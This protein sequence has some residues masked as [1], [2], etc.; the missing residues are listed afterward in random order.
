MRTACPSYN[1]RP[2]RV[3]GR[4]LLVVAVLLAACGRQAVD[5][6]HDR[7]EAIRA[8][9]FLTCGIWPEVRGFAMAAPGGGYAGF[10]VDICRAVAA[11]I[12]GDP[13]QA[14]FV[15]TR[16]VPDFLASADTDLVA[17][18]LTWMLSRERPVGLRFG[19]VTFHDGQTFLVPRASGVT[20]MAELSGRSICMETGSP[21]E[22]SIA[23]LFRARGL[24]LEEVHLE[25]ESD[26]GAA[27]AS[28]RC[29]AYTGDQTMLGSIRAGLP[30]PADFVILSELVSK[31]PLAPVVRQ[32][33]TRLLDVLQWTVFALVAAE[34]LG[35]TSANVER[36]LA[37]DDYD[38][39]RLLGV[40]PGNGSALG[41]S[42]RW[43]F[44]A[45]AAV[46]NY[47]EIFERHLGTASNIGLERGPNRLAR[48]GGLMWAPPI[49]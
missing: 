44:D 17:R 11:A 45:I 22:F 31:E 47:G 15:Q 33:D 25:P 23:S 46:G 32:T 41:L 8:R 30:R 42:E 13:T 2:A 40:E 10:D 20:Q 16:T 27:L 34:E 39:R 6:Q 37:S 49:R 14:R 35:V 29:E 26:V 12:L 1:R 18:R 43:A 4:A 36:M 28:G 5:A 38:V 24:A 19:P 3:L 9:G 21:A 7:V 48:D